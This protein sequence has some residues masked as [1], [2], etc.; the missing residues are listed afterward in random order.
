MEIGN[1]GGLLEIPGVGIN[2]FDLNRHYRVTIADEQ[3]ETNVTC[4]VKEKDITRSMLPCIVN[5]QTD[6]T[7]GI[8]YT[9]QVNGDNRCL[10]TL[11]RF[12]KI[13]LVQ[14]ACFQLKEL[15]RSHA[16]LINYK[17]WSNYGVAIA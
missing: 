5:S 10:F 15:L 11:A 17:Y 4:L 12:F 6:I 9:V 3:T 7:I 13:A 1:D 16:N 8:R 2:L 14:D